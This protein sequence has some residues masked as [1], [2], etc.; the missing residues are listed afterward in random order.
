[1]KRYQT[2]ALERLRAYLEACRTL[3][4]A[5]AYAKATEDAEA[6]GRL[7]GGRKYVPLGEV[8]FVSIKIPTG[9]GKTIVGAHALKL[10]AEATGTDTPLVLWLAP[11]DTIRR[12]TA[13]AL[14]N[15][16]HPYHEALEDAFGAGRVRVFDLAEKDR[17]R[18]PDIAQ[19]VCIVVST[20]QAFVKEKRQKYDVYRD[21]EALEAHFAPLP[22]GVPPGMDARADDPSRPAASFANLCVLHRPVIVAD[23]VHHA[24][25]DLAWKTLASLSPRAIIGLSATPK[26][27]NNVLWAVRASELFEEEMVKLPV[28][29][30][31]YPAGQCPWSMPVL[32]ALGLREKLE[33]LALAEWDGGHGAPWLRPIALFQAQSDVKGDEERVT[34]GRLRKFLVEEA[35]RSAEEVVV[36]T[37]EQKELDGK[38]V[39]DPKCP[40]RIVITV[41]ALKEGWDCPSAAVLCSVGNIRSETAAVQLLGRVMRQPGA[42]RRKTPELNRAYAFVVSDGFGAAAA[43]LAAGLRQRGFDEGEAERAIRPEPPVLGGPDGIFG[44]RPDAVRLPPEVYCAVAAALPAEVRVVANVDGGAS[45]G[46]GADLSADAAKAVVDALERAGGDSATAL[47]A[48]WRAK[49]AAARRRAEEEEAAP[50]RKRRIVL[51]SLAARLKEDQEVL[52]FGTDDAY[53]EIC[54]GFAEFLPA[55]LPE[56]AFRMERSGDEFQLFLDGEAIQYKMASGG[57]QT[58]FAGEGFGTQVDEGNV[59][60]ALDRLTPNAFISV[61]E[62]RG[63]IARIVA[64]RVAGGTPPDALFGHRHALAGVL[65]RELEKACAAA[66]RK[67]YQMVFRIGGCDAAT[68]ELRWEEAEAF[69]LDAAFA[70]SF[71]AGLGMYDGSYLFQKHF[72]GRW[73]VPAFDGAKPHGEGEEF[74]CACL[75]DAHPAVATWLRNPANHPGAFRLP[76]TGGWFYPDFVGELADGRFFAIEYKGEMLAS[77][78]DTVEKTAVGKL[79]AELSAGRCVYATVVKRDAGGRD[80]RTQLD[81]LF[82]PTEA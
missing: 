19:G 17:I 9:G 24:A 52:L 61:A 54:E 46:V 14:G 49:H 34:A 40:V 60:N 42:K 39:R 11:T 13:E 38:D 16:R 30:T 27:A 15:P 3:D 12:Q 73:R 69:A 76:V 23:E 47:A 35:G 75:I 33:Q 37:G 21:G 51:P 71:G 79:W 10:A 22:P 67:A 45:I 56:G 36:V 74:G 50:C 70:D 55:A 2:E 72:L 48:Q 25:T 43:A 82:R 41:D 81:R 59:V 18:P 64:G 57:M 32:A 28:E 66:R 7:G 26:G 6:A 31:E 44:E 65:R 1:M 77:T 62:K 78:P 80:V 5:A 63:W 20:M 8:P 58:E 29:L 53:S 68:P 4:P